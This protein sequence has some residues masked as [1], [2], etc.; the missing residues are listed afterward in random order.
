MIAAYRAGAVIILENPERKIAMQLRDDTR[1]RDHWGLF[2]G[3][4]KDNESPFDAIQRE[5]REELSVTLLSAKLTLKGVHDLPAI[6][7]TCSVFHYPV[8]DELDNAVLREGLTWRFML[9]EEIL[10][11]PMVTHQL[12]MLQHYYG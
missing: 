2:G 11:V 1:W 3:W 9:L 6:P 10:R 7:A 12:M 4:L 8:T 5:I